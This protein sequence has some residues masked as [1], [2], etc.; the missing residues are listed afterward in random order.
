MEGWVAM[1]GA[2]GTVLGALGGGLSVWLKMRHA[3]TIETNE[4][5]HKHDADNSAHHQAVQADAVAAYVKLLDRQEKQIQQLITDSEDKQE[6]IDRMA[7]EGQHCREAFARLD[8]WTRW[9][10]KKLEWQDEAL[11]NLGQKTGEHVKAPKLQLKEFNFEFHARSSAH[12]T[13][14]LR[15]GMR[16]EDEGK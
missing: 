2:I 6:I 10:E 7:I 12:D 8:Q 15:E 4:Q 16:K 5:R 13:S 9:A 3:H 14:V 1:L 11:R